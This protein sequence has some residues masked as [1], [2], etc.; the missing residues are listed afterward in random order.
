M[1]DRFQEWIDQLKLLFDDLE[2]ILFFVK[3]A[4]GRFLYANP[5]H[6]RHLRRKSLSEILH[7]TD[8]AFY[9]PSLAD[10]YWK[11][12]QGVIRTGKTIAHQIEIVRN[13]KGEMRWHSTTKIP[14][15]NP[16][17]KVMGL[18]GITRDLQQGAVLMRKYEG[19]QRAVEKIEE[20]FAS[21]I[22]SADLAKAAGLSVRQL[23]RQFQSVF[24]KSPREFITQRRLE[25][26]KRLL[27]ESSDKI[28]M[29]A[30]D[31]GFFDHSHFT[32][33]YRSAFGMTPLEERHRKQG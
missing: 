14:Y 15:K 31:C 12:D 29:I 13:P 30:L 22:L 25:E 33:A 5:A 3:D 1:N 6:V 17:G 23:E 28:S 10:R 4:Q 19:L 21:E 32:K 27:T 11:D 8:H 26:A 16:R 24:L 9:P 2:E 7:Q 20:D 18:A